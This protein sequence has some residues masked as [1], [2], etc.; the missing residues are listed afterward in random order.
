MMLLEIV[1][2]LKPDYS[3]NESIWVES[4]LTNEEILA[5]VNETFEE[6]YYY[7]VLK[8]RTIIE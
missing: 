3:E 5:K 1:V 2:F 8:E 6:W 4:S 7:D